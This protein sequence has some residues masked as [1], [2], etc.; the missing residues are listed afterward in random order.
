MKDESSR[1]IGRNPPAPDNGGVSRP[2]AP[3]NGAVAAAPPAGR[4]E[5]VRGLSRETGLGLSARD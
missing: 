5:S 3:G 2:L 1:R 4:P